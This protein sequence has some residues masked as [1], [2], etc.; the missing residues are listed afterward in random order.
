MLMM[1]AKSAT[2]V[3]RKLIVFWNKGYYVIIF[4]HDVANKT[5]S[6]ALIMLFVM[7][8][9]FGNSSIF[10]ISFYHNFYHK[11]S[12]VQFNKDMTCQGDFHRSGLDSNSGL[13]V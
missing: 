11:L 5:L 12:Q 13:K 9:K 2:P 3:L 6:I 4:F 7:W 10:I 8:L 1:S